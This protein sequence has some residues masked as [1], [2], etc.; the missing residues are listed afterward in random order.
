MKK[1]CE[2]CKNRVPYVNDPEHYVCK[3]ADVVQRVTADHKACSRYD[4][5]YKSK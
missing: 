5:A 2:M 1:I 4:A 3:K